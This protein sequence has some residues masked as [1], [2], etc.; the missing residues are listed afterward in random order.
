MKLKNVFT[1]ALAAAVLLSCVA[2]GSP[3]TG[4][5]SGNNSVQ[6]SGSSS[7]AEKKDSVVIAVSAEISTLDP[8]NASGTVTATMFYNMFDCLTRTNA[9]G[10]V[11]CLL[12]ESYQ[13]LDDTT[14]QFKLRQG[15]TF[16]N[17]EQFNADTVKFS[18]ERILNEDYGSALLGDF[19]DL[20]AVEIV[21]EYTVNIITKE[22]FPSLPLRLSYLAMVPAQYI[23]E[24]GDEYFAANPVGTGAYQ[25][26]SYD[27][28]SQL[29]L[30]AN[31]NYFL[32]VPEIKEVTFKIIKEESTRVMAVQSNEVDIAMS[33]PVSQVGTIEAAKGY[34]IVAGPANRT[35][36]LGMNT[37]TNPA[38]ANREVRQAICYAIDMDTIINTIL[39][40]YAG[41]TAA[42]SL[43]EWSGY[44]SSIEPYGYDPD[45]AKQLLAQA[46]YDS[47]LELEVAV[48]DGEY[49]CFAQVAEAI[50]GQLQSVGVNAVVSYYERSVMRGAVRDNTVPGLYIMGLGGPYAEN[51]Q[52]LRIICGSGER[53]STWENPEFDA[54][55]AQAGSDFDEASR[56]ATWSRIQQ[57]IKDEA[58]V[59]SLYQL[60]GIYAISDALDWT[61]RLDEVILVK[62]ISA[63]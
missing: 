37:I 23:T 51:N 35:M 59:Y 21:D 38:L 5:N 14:W 10:E 20:S 36:F 11:E 15:V 26:V 13:N 17:G 54:L 8:H 57:L 1:G 28:G 29:T 7:G 42:L 16:T 18:V 27:E 62:D 24:H 19:A 33:I 4:G 60:Y 30:R 39:G 2:C 40:G 48:V 6:S 58:P 9:A 56:N 22:A 44:D 43:P 52:T 41:T 25:M 61:P 50:A 46:G 12:A 63:R 47:G 31:P 49:P 3:G 53:F 32:G 55:R 34:S 45:L